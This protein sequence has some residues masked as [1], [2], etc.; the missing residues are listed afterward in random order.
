[1]INLAPAPAP[2]RQKELGAFYTPPAMARVLTNWAVRSP[3]D[4]ALDPSFGGLVF[5]A[6][7]RD[8]LRELGAQDDAIAKQL[9]GVD[10]DGD[11]HAAAREGGWLGLDRGH[12][13]REDFFSVESSRLPPFEALIGNPPYIRYQDFNGSASAARQLALDAGVKLTGLASSWAPFVVHATSFVAPGGRLAQVLPAELLHAQYARE[14][15]QF[16][17]R[18][19]ER[20]FIAVFDERVFPGAL[21]DVVLL[22]AEGRGAKGM[23]EVRLVPC[24]SVA[25]V[26]Q[27]LK[28]A[29]E[30]KSD[31]PRATGNGR[32]LSQLL[33]AEAH[34]LYDRTAA[35]REVH[36]LG[37]IASVD[38]GIVTGANA[39]F[40]LDQDAAAE[41][42][43]DLL[44]PAVA[45]AAQVAGARLSAQDHR[46]LLHRGQRG[47]MLVADAGTPAE[48]LASVQDHLARGERAE[49]HERYKCR[50]RDPWWALPIPQQ[51]APDLLLTY[52]SNEHPRL[53]LN[54]AKVLNTNTIHGVRVSDGVEARVLAAGFYNSLTLL[55]AELEGRS[56]GGG[57]LKLEPTEAEALLLPPL[58]LE[59]AALLPAV[60]QAVRARDI[61]AAAELV[62]P[63]TLGALGFDAN[64]ITRLRLARRQLQLRRKS[65]GRKPA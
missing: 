9:F 15:V 14:V 6:A 60:D 53:A 33:P 18:E 11:A 42:H 29:G 49:L 28:E 50:I 64:D 46:E 23:A 1:M 37:E 24:A 40:V 55:S 27:Q 65:R 21:E 61:D 31:R 44:K 59:L 2:S 22:F 7:A 19:F 12:F 32:L 30:A 47:L 45:K 57:V 43:S 41:M 17:C 39:F 10:V 35:H 34:R 62:D 8:R 54:D 36:R 56:Y 3:R 48:V 63:L 58:P 20:I 51:G 5:L 38:I 26:E 25:D 16:L 13:L 4:R 52:C